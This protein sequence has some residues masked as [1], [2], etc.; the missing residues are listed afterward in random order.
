M[1]QFN[2]GDRKAVRAAQK[3]A[4]Q[5]SALHRSTMASIMSSISGRHWMYDVL[6]SCGCFNT[7]FTGEALSTSFNEGKR[8]V[9]LGLLDTIMQAC[10]DLY[11]TMTREANDRANANTARNTRGS[12]PT[13]RNPDPDTSSTRYTSLFDGDTPEDGDDG[14]EGGS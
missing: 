5:V 2:A 14:E 1:E 7:T 9:G 12:E 10:P 11:V 4:A 13:A 8:A 6:A 3:Q